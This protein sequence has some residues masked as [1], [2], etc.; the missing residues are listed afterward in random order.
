MNK[1]C[2]IDD[3]DNIGGLDAKATGLAVTIFGALL[4]LTI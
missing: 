2:I 4:E 1:S 3:Y